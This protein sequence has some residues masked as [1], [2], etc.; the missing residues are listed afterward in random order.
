[1]V[2]CA[3]ASR[4]ESNKTTVNLFRSNIVDR[5]FL[6]GVQGQ[7]VRVF[8]DAANTT[9][10]TDRPALTL[11]PE[12]AGAGGGGDA[13]LLLTAIYFYIPTWS[14]HLAFHPLQAAQRRLYGI[15]SIA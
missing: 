11:K 12:C 8:I 9:L 6:I 10:L 5:I 7:F 3:V 14:R 1:M 15:G 4:V 13:Q 2:D